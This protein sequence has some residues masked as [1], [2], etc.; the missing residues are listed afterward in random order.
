MSITYTSILLP[1][2]STNFSSGVPERVSFMEEPQVKIEGMLFSDRDAFI[3]Y[4]MDEISMS[5]DSGDILIP[6]HLQTAEE[7]DEWIM[8]L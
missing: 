1:M 8:S 3:N 4:P 7:M 5:L 6:S 2:A